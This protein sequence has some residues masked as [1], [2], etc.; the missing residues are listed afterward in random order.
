MNLIRKAFQEM[1]ALKDVKEGRVPRYESSVLKPFIKDEKGFSPIQK[2]SDKLN[3]IVMNRPA[4]KPAV[5]RPTYFEI[6]K[7]EIHTKT[8]L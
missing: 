8:M 1:T 4:I 7:P 2:F 3:Q 5:M 6:K